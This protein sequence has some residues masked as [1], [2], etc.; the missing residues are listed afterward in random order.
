MQITHSNFYLSRDL[1]ARLSPA[2]SL[3]MIGFILF[4]GS[5]LPAT[6]YSVNVAS[7]QTRKA[8]TTEAARNRGGGDNTLEI[9][10]LKTLNYT[11]PNDCF[12]LYN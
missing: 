10:C 6:E 12:K 11:Q 5:V 3:L 2:V 9:M 7:L 8:T 1:N 4:K